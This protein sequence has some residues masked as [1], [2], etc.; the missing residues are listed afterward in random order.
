MLLGAVA[1]AAVNAFWFGVVAVLARTPEPFYGPA[2]VIAALVLMHMAENE[3]ENPNTG[4]LALWVILATVVIDRW[5]D[6]PWPAVMLAAGTIELFWLI[7]IKTYRVGRF[8]RDGRGARLGRARLE[9]DD[10]VG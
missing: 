9:P 1:L 4:A 8:G 10:S 3:S 5:F 7:R 6:R 2:A